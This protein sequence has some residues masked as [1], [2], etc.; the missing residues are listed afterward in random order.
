MVNVVLWSGTVA[1]DILFYFEHAVFCLKKRISVSAQYSTVI[2]Q[3]LQQ[4][5]PSVLS[6]HCL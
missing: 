1:I 2:R 5:R 4:Q 3:I 6:P